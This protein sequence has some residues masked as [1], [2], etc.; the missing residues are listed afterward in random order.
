LN[1]RRDGQAGLPGHNRENALIEAIA[2]DRSRAT[3]QR[4]FTHPDLRKLVHY[5]SGE[6]TGPCPLVL[7]R[8][9]SSNNRA[10]RFTCSE[11]ADVTEIGADERT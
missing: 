6:P 5:F 10:A 3:A 4:L 2:P 9:G 8:S 11:S 1:L 7:K